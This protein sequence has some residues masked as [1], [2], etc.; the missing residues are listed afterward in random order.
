MPTPG[1]YPH[2]PLFFPASSLLSG[3]I[4]G[5]IT[6][7]R[8]PGR[9]HRATQRSRRSPPR[10]GA[11]T[12]CCRRSVLRAGW[13]SWDGAW[14]C[15]RHC[16]D[17]GNRGRLSEALCCC[18]CQYGWE[19]SKQD[20]CQVLRK[21]SAACGYDVDFSS[22]TNSIKKKKTKTKQLLLSND[23][24]AGAWVDSFDGGIIVYCG[25]YWL[26]YW[27]KNK[28]KLLTPNGKLNKS[29]WSSCEIR[30]QQVVKSSQFW[31]VQ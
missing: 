25:T 31:T 18:C 4:F 28:L 1:C 15:R 6:H 27:L 23:F 24:A 16:S 9:R 14:S 11:R 13:R 2:L 3:C 17:P 21:S 30:A 7:W 20:Y 26:V 29:Y 10:T 8:R 22:S 12:R 19:R 5:K